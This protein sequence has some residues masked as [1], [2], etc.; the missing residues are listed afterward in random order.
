MKPTR[1]SFFETKLGHHAILEDRLRVACEAE[2]L[3]FRSWVHLFS[4]ISWI[5]FHSRAGGSVPLPTI[6]LFGAVR[7]FSL[8]A[9]VRPRM[10]APERKPAISTYGCQL[11]RGI[12]APASMRYA[13]EQACIV[14]RLM[15]PRDV[16]HA[17]Y[18]NGQPPTRLACSRL[19]RLF[20]TPCLPP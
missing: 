1:C 18:A 14:A 15:T 16:Q 4:D 12:P 6:G 10:K 9:P 20:R 11:R 13:H 7:P 5:R 17:P 8:P 3:I 2:D 19:V